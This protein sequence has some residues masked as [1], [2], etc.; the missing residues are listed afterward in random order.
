[1]PSIA[2]EK[3]AADP[4]RKY[5]ANFTAVNDTPTTSDS[6]T[7]RDSSAGTWRKEARI[8]SAILAARGGARVFAHCLLDALRHQH[9][10][11]AAFGPVAGGH[12]AGDGHA[13]AVQLFRT[14]PDL[15]H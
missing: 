9:L 13:P 5:A 1:M 11:V 6:R 8:A 4:V 2:S 12:P 10:R 7:A 3:T 15:R 14:L